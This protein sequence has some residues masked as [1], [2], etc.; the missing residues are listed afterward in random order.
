MNTTEH[1]FILIYSVSGCSGGTPA[2]WSNLEGAADQPKSLSGALNIVERS[3][4]IELEG[5][6]GH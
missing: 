1:A 5:I 4:Q 3:R 6:P 2:V